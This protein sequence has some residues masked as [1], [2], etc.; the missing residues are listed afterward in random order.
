MGRVPRSPPPRARGIAGARADHDDRVDVARLDGVVHDPGALRAVAGQQCLHD[1]RV[2]PL[3]PQL[4]QALRDRPPGQLVP[5]RQAVGPHL[6]HAGDLGLGERLQPGAEQRGGE[7]E[8][9]VR[10]DH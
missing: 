5:E 3:P 10:R 2:E 9:D 8:V 6:E 4:G 7:V 1:R